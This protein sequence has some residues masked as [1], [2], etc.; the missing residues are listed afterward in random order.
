MQQRCLLVHLFSVE[1]IALTFQRDLS[2]DSIARAAGGD[3]AAFTALVAAY[4]SDLMRVSYVILGDHSLAEDAVQNAWARGWQRLHTLRD[5]TKVR[6]WLIAIAANEARQMARRVSRT[7]AANWQGY[8]SDAD[9]SQIDLRDALATLSVDDRRL[10][11][12]RYA[13][14]LTS[15]E[16][17]DVLG[18]SAGA[19]RSRL[20]RLIA[21][22]RTELDRE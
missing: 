22:L 11:G 12:L 2:S 15:A 9:P 13:L 21:R 7:S 18:L 20:M 6:S 4:N 19:V 10:L 17:G 16:V 14:D 1:A 3:R 5:P 8:G